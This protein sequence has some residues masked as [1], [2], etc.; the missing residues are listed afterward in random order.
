M[1]STANFSW[2]AG[3]I[4]IIIINSISVPF[5]VLLNVLVI[6]AVKTRPRLQTNSNILLACLA[7][8]DALTGLFG[9]SL[10]ILWRLFELFNLKS[11]ETVEGFHIDV[12]SVLLIVS[13]LHLILVTFE[14]L[15]AIKFAMQYSNVVTHNNIKIAVTVCWLAA[16]AI[17]ILRTVKLRV[18]F[19][20]MLVL[21]IF[22]CIVFVAFTYM[23]LYHETRRHQR[24][25][26]AQQLPQ[27]EVERFTK[28]NKALKT[29]VL[30]VGAVIICLL[31]LSFCS[32]GSISGI[33]NNCPISRRLRQT[34]IM[35]NSLVNPIIYCCRQR[36]MRTFVFGIRTRLVHPAS[37]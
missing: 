33:L 32:I 31:P 30:V 10:Y 4:I 20:S 1:A 37:E 16:I 13:C 17:A 29:T 27:E 9:Q 2:E 25:I 5:T 36:E 34:C 15:I 26:K 11:S 19:I 12:M 18:V 21:V 35:L 3:H 6:K 8:T 14:R 7:V 23:I 28:E 22:S 24:K